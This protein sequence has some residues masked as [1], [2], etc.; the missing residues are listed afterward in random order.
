[1]NNFFRRSLTGAGIV[2]FILGG[3]YLHPLTFFITGLVILAGSLY[4][5]YHLTR[6]AG[7]NPQM[8][9]G[10]GAGI[11]LYSLSA[12]VASGILDHTYLVLAPLVTVA[13]IITELY[14][15]DQTRPFDSIAHTLFSLL[16]IA[17]PLCLFIFASFSFGGPGPLIP[18]LFSDFSPAVV[19]GFFLLIWAN[20]TGAYLVGITF[21]RHRLMERVSPKKSW[22]G[23]AGGVAASV[24]ASFAVHAWLGTVNQY[25]WIIIALI[26][27]AAGTWGDLAESMLKRSIGVKDSGN[28]LPGHG[29]FLDRFDSVLFSFPVVYM[30]LLLFG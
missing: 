20:D 12:L 15:K 25:G 18:G 4:E 24:L 28:S 9:T 10:L 8:L 22:E 7:I 11:I 2:I 3:F 5:Y 19:I 13:V 29:G 26:V 6:K 21:G 17:L 23:L 30:Y 14:R 27:S 16:Y 1:M